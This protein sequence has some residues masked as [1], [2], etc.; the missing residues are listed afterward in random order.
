[1]VLTSI[2]FRHEL[3]VPDF[4]LRRLEQKL[5]FEHLSARFGRTAFDPRGNLVLEDV[6]LF[7]SGIQE[8]IARAASVRLHLDVFSVTSGDFDVRKVEVSGARFDCPAMVSPSG[9]SEPLVADFGATIQHEGAEWS[10]PDATFLA[11]RVFVT[12]SVSWQAP[13]ATKDRKPVPANLLKNYIAWARKG[14]ETLRSTDQ[15]EGARAHLSIVAEPNSP[16][17][18]HAE[19][20]VARATAAVRPEL[21]PVVVED[22]FARID[23]AWRLSGL[24]P[25]TI[26]AS[27]GKVAGPYDIVVA[28][29]ALRTSGHLSFQ[30]LHWTGGPVEVTAAAVS[31]DADTAAHPRVTVHFDSVSHLEA[32][33]AALARGTSPIA[34]QLELDT[35]A[36]SAAVA[37]DATLAPDLLND[38]AAR[39]A[40]WRKSR[41]LAQLSFSEPAS[42]VG[43]ID[44]APGWKLREAR[45]NAHLGAAVAYGTALAAT[46]AEVVVDPQRLLVEPLVF[47]S[48]DTA[49]RGSYGMDL[50]TQDYRF[51]LQGHFFPSVIDS[52]F[53]G[54][55]TR[56]WDDF[57]FGARPPDADLDIIGRWRSPE[58]SIVYGWADIAPVALRGVPLDR[59]K[60]TFFIRP[61][62]YDIISF[63]ARRGPLVATGGF[64]RHDD[65]ETKKPRWI[66]FDF[67]ST[68]PLAEGA[69]LFGPEGART[70]E[71]FVF[72]QAPDVRA[73]GRMEWGED[74]LHQNIGVKA[75][76]PGVFRFHQFP[77]EN[78]RLAFDLVDR[79][80][81]IH[82]IEA[83]LAGGALVG[84]ATVSGPEEDRRLAFSGTLQSAN[85]SRMVR[86][87]MDY[88]ALT[89]PP[90]TPPL[91]DSANRLGEEGR[92]NLNLTAAGPLANLYALQGD[93]AVTVRGA[94][95]ADIEMFGLLSRVLRGTLFGFT[96]LQFSD[97]TAKFAL[98][99]EH[100]DFSTLKLTGQTAAIRGKGRYTM[101]TSTLNFNVALFPFR[102]SSFPVFGIVN[103]VL[104]PFSH[105]FEIRLA[106][107]L[108]KPEWSFAA[109]A[110]SLPTESTVPLA[111]APAGDQGGS[112]EKPPAPPAH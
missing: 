103:T 74:G 111:P 112:G 36:R 108:D 46:E 9:V 75:S 22:L 104:T 106:G 85:L 48:R 64:T 43:R 12:A 105:I 11:G 37:V 57:K 34:L 45:A 23:T 25:V 33:I 38:A 94:K 50:K 18:L 44:L 21:P 32:E 30:P 42:L 102:E 27:A 28:H 13:A 10:V 31:R 68:L 7:G 88:R 16:P 109:G 39:A 77:V 53:S 24:D 61:E 62:H 73:S 41:I 110:E 95:L 35:A 99:G 49:V 15:L 58:R 91:P 80:I 5:E 93:G 101:P 107:T 63:D 3:T 19:L 83:E 2:A 82:G 78:A 20:A 70:V 90:G 6:R 56:L 14:A 100:L 96:S 65:S 72:E 92:L 97:A 29:P 71:P 17:R 84:S 67:Q 52:W 69:R 55:W 51:L 66:T 1:V 81:R 40:V 54:W 87:W 47:R 8:P 89:A 26:R 4:L 98:N 76:A 60:A 59:L 86:T 79:E